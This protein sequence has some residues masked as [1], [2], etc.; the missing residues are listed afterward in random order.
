MISLVVVHDHHKNIRNKN[1]NIKPEKKKKNNNNKQ[2]VENELYSKLHQLWIQERHCPE[3]LQYDPIMVTN[4]LQQFEEMQE[5]I[6]DLSESSMGKDL[7]MAGLAQQDLDRAKFTLSDWLTVRL[8]KIEKYPLYIMRNEDTKELLSETEYEYCKAY[9]M[10]VIDHLEKTV[11]DHIP[12][13]WRK[14][15][16]PNMIDTPD[17]EGYHF[18]LV[19][20]TILDK[21]GNDLDVGS[22]VVA[23]YIDMKDNMLQ[24]KV[25]ILI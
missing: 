23:K 16:L 13:A 17:F 1:R 11:T 9:E 10:L 3:L 2:A 12:E 4:L 18:W 20:E 21:E 22:C 25:D 6:D 19:K 8:N 14:L 5:A 15:D 7:L 24:D